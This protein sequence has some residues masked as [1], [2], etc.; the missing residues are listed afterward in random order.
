LLLDVAILHLAIEFV[1]LGCAIGLYASIS[2][3]FEVLGFLFL[4]FVLLLT[5]FDDFNAMAF[6]CPP[7][8]CNRNDYLNRVLFIH[9]SIKKSWHLDLVHEEISKSIY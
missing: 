4:A 6:G 2:S 9:K 1:G 5:C 7:R 8:K 3:W